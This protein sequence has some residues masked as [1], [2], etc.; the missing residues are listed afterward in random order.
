VED[1]DDQR[2]SIIDLIGT[3]DDVEVTAVGSA[4]AALA[5][6][7]KQQFDCMVLDLKLPDT[8]G[9]ILLERLKTDDRFARC[10]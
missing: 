8:T 7:E 5:A 9:F 10:R 4:D 6:L 2:N 1:D 3:G